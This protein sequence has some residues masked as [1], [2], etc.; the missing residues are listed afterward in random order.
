M[1]RFALIGLF[2]IVGACSKSN[3]GSSAKVNK[4]KPMP[5]L[6]SE[7]IVFA[8]FMKKFKYAKHKLKLA[9]VTCY[10][11]KKWHAH[12]EVEQMAFKVR[13]SFHLGYKEK[14]GVIN[15]LYVPNVDF[16]KPEERKAKNIYYPGDTV[17]FKGTLNVQFAPNKSNI[18]GLNLSLVKDER[19]KQAGS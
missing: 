15:S 10:E 3:T 11:Q 14:D 19:V 4:D 8:A 7:G 13:N 12:C 17:I 2:L 9:G 6:D 16:M 18:S 5:Q 1:L